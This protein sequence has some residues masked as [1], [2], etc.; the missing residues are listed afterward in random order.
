[1]KHELFTRI[2]L[3]LCSVLFSYL[4]IILGYSFSPEVGLYG[5]SPE[6]LREAALNTSI[7]YAISGLLFLST[8]AVGVVGAKTTGINTILLLSL[9]I[10]VAVGLSIVSISWFMFVH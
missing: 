10:G 5:T 9:G 3:I 4:L 7:L 2:V 8:V 6:I 1:M